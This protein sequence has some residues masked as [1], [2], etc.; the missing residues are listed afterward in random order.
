MQALIYGF[1]KSHSMG[2]RK[3]CFYLWTFA[4]FVS[5]PY[6]VGFNIW[7]N[8]V[9]QGMNQDEKCVYSIVA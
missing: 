6:M 8:L 2:K 9:L 4:S 5:L 3:L 1:F 7:G